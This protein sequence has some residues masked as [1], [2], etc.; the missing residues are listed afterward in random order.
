MKKIISITIFLLLIIILTRPTSAQIGINISGVTCGNASAKDDAKLCCA[1][2]PTTA[3][4][5]GIIGKIKENPLV[6]WVAT[7]LEGLQKGVGQMQRDTKYIDCAIGFSDTSSGQCVC[8]S[9]LSITP[10]PIKALE[11]MC[12]KYMDKT[13]DAD[14]CVSCANSGGVYTGL[15]CIQADLSGFIT[16]TLLGWG[17]GLASIF[18]LLCIIYSAFQLQTSRGNAEKIKKAQEL[19]TSCIMGLMLIIFSIFILR[20]IGVGILQIPG[21]Q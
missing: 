2:Q 5:Q 14:S 8:V 4:T 18:A 7:P 11:Q 6:G 1:P 16:K 19:L 15:G 3:D 13:P 10:S 17:I 20:V 9:Q 12:H 21:F